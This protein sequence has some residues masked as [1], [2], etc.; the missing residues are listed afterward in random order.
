MIGYRSKQNVLLRKALHGIARP[1]LAFNQIINKTY[2]T[3]MTLYCLARW[4]GSARGIIVPES[5]KHQSI[6]K[7]SQYDIVPLKTQ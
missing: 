6:G 4:N 3:I 2:N 7:D 1:L 5:V